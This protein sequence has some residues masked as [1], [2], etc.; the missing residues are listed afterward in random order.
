[1]LFWFKQGSSRVVVNLVIFKHGRSGLVALLIVT[2]K[3]KGGGDHGCCD[4]CNM[5]KVGRWKAWLMFW[6][7]HGRSRIMVDMVV[8]LFLHEMHICLNTEE[9]GWWKAKMLCC[10]CKWCITFWNTEDIWWWWAWLICCFCTSCN[11]DSKMENFHVQGTF[12]I[13][14][15]NSNIFRWQS[16][17]LTLISFHLSAFFDHSLQNTTHCVHCTD[18]ITHCVQNTQPFQ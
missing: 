9:E 12:Q 2:W 16:I 5:G 13:V 17:S 11:T 10:Y 15:M 18:K 3:N 7:I 6:F 4:V 8:A 1:M 14:F